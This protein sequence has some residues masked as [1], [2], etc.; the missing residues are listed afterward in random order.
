MPR[1]FISY[2]RADKEKVFAIKD[3]I[4]AA[5]GEKCWIDLNGIESDAQFANVII[6]AIDEAEIFL[7]MYSKKHSKIKD[8]EKDWTVREISYAQ[9]EGKRIIF[10]NIDKTPLTKWFKF[11]F[12]SKQQ[13]DATSSEAFNHL[14]IDICRWLRIIRKDNIISDNR[15]T[16]IYKWL[17]RG[18]TL[19]FGILCVALLVSIS[20]VILNKSIKSIPYNSLSTTQADSIIDTYS[21]KEEPDKKFSIIDSNPVKEESSIIEKRTLN[22]NSNNVHMT[23]TQKVDKT[24]SKKQSQTS[25]Q[26]NDIV[27]ENQNIEQPNQQ[28][29]QKSE[30][31]IC[32]YI[33]FKT[34]QADIDNSGLITIRMAAERM[35]E[36]TMLCALITGYGDN[37]EELK[38]AQERARAVEK[39]LIEF[40][41]SSKRIYTKEYE[42][43]DSYPKKSQLYKRRVTIQLKTSY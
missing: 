28:P 21:V 18:S 8:Y 5:T 1:I 30:I 7:F 37:G 15:L 31:D 14:L 6:K 25:P 34:N 20:L 35:I 11:M 41:I 2:K 26:R 27:K 24:P 19:A 23:D 42:I 17:R 40:G 16:V 36:D 32:Y 38:L 22:S 43:D 3:K 29:V 13:V 9:A 10:V 12:S 33:Y 4:E 39:E